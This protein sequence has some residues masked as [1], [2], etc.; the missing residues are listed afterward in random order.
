M[1]KD[2]SQ[3]KSNPLA[4]INSQCFYRKN[5]KKLNEIVLNLK[6]KNADIIMTHYSNHAKKIVKKNE[7]YKEI[8]AVGGSGMVSEVINGMNLKKQT[9]GILPVGYTNSLA[10]ELNIKSWKHALTVFEQ[11][12]ISHIDLIKVTIIDKDDNISIRQIA[13]SCSIGYFNHL[14]LKQ[15]PVKNI[16]E[17]IEKKVDLS[18]IQKPF[19]VKGRIENGDWN[20]IT[21]TDIIIGNTSY[22][23]NKYIFKNANLQDDFFH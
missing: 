17:R 3:I 1:L 13:S 11:K 15:Y 16:F 20:E 10:M 7:T 2:D 5:Q 19:L 22:I 23:Q 21:L 12:K 14:R 6:K 8:I 4:I 18:S 9:L